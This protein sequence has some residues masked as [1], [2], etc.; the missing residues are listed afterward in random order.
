M[1]LKYS[2]DFILGA[3]ITNQSKALI[4]LGLAFFVPFCSS[5]LLGCSSHH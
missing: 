4:A 3:V 2:N 1:V 5:V